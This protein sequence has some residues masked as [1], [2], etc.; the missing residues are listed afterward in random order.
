MLSSSELANFDGFLYYGH[1]SFGTGFVYT[2][3]T[4]SRLVPITPQRILD[5]RTVPGRS[6]ITNARG[7]IDSSGRLIGGH[8]ISVSLATLEVAARAAFGNLT[9]VSPAGSGYLTISSGGTRPGTSSVNYVA[10]AISSNFLVTGT[11]D[12]DTVSIYSRATTHVVLDITAFAVGSPRTS[13]RRVCHCRLGLDTSTPCRSRQGR[14]LAGLVPR[15]LTA[16]PASRPGR[17]R[18]P[19]PSPLAGVR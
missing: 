2:E 18:Q 4:A 16:D 7:N 1:D 5:T 19:P 14:H 13:Q 6:H 11:S 17:D 8:T 12:T 9:A 10:N 15:S 3:L